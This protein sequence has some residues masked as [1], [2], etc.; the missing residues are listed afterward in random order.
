MVV[1]S[2]YCSFSGS[3]FNSQHP[4]CGLHLFV[5]PVPGYQTTSFGLHGEACMQV[6]KIPVYINK[7]G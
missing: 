6:G 4:P 1:R 5:T 3:G 7:K 2:A